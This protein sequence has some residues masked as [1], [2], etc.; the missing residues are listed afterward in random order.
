VILEFK[1]QCEL[2]SVQGAIDNTH[3]SIL[4]PKVDFVE[5]YYVHKTKGYSIVV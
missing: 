1:E 4:K 3:I 5:D 2:S